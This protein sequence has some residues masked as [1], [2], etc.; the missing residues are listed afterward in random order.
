MANSSF[1]YLELI[2]FLL[3]FSGDQRCKEHPEKSSHSGGCSHKHHL[4]ANWCGASSKGG[5]METTRF[6]ASFHASTCF[7]PNSIPKGQTQLVPS[8]QRT[9][10]QHTVFLQQE[11]EGQTRTLHACLSTLMSCTSRLRNTNEQ[12]CFFQL[13]C[14]VHY[15][16]KNNKPSVLLFLSLCTKQFGESV[17]PVQ[18]IL[19]LS[20]VKFMKVNDKAQIA[21]CCRTFT[22][23]NLLETQRAS[24]HILQRSNNFFRTLRIP[25][26]LEQ[27]ATSE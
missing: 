23:D 8:V 9:A 7:V 15:S 22:L 2:Q 25:S 21:A 13:V 10:E 17:H 16:R 14:Y 19:C 1:W 18:P 6:Q 4:P 20:L 12:L 26:R 11:K 3:C 27:T 5:C 24:Q